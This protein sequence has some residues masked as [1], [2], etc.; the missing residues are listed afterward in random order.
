MCS[1]SNSKHESN[2]RI[3][4]TST[5]N[6]VLVEPV[7]EVIPQKWLMLTLNWSAQSKT[8][9]AKNNGTNQDYSKNQ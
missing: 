6:F 5:H 2:R 3:K 1:N 9:Q 8:K 4:W 7:G